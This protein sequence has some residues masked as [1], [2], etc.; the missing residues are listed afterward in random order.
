MCV[1]YICFVF[2]SLVANLAA[3][4][5][6]LV[7]FLDDPFIW[8]LVEKAKVFYTAVRCLIFV[9]KMYIMYNDSPCI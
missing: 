2:R 5:C 9:F 3:A 7:D 4:N 6:F 8:K 1:D